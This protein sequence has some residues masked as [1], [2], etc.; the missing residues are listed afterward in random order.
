MCDVY[1]GRY[2]TVRDN[3]TLS[4]PPD[5]FSHHQCYKKCFH[6]IKASCQLEATAFSSAWNTDT[7]LILKRTLGLWP[8]WTCQMLHSETTPDP[9]APV[10]IKCGW[11]GVGDVVTAS[12]DLWVR[13]EPNCGHILHIYIRL[14]ICTLDVYVTE[15][16]RE[17][18]MSVLLHQDEV[19][20]AW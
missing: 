16:L 13:A 1:P 7:Y 20:Q 3:W 8:L 10:G 14:S 17:G 18:Q 4:A 12:N 15:D 2:T 11:T 19:W 5:G 9:R 6:V